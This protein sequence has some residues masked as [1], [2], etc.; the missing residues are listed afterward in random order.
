[1][2]CTTYSENVTNLVHATVYFT[3]SMTMIET[4]ILYNLYYIYQMKHFIIK[5]LY[6]LLLSQM[7]ENPIIIDG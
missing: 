7:F 2:H 5:L 1:M 6:K 4:T 3:M